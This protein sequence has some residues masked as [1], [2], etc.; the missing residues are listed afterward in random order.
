[1]LVYCNQTTS[2]LESFKTLLHLHPK[3]LIMAVE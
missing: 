2:V 1:M 3:L